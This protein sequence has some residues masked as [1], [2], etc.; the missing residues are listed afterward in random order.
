MQ[1][2]TEETTITVPVI[3]SVDPLKQWIDWTLSDLGMHYRQSPLSWLRVSDS[4]SSGDRL[5]DVSVIA[6]SHS[7]SLHHVLTYDKWTLIFNT[8]AIDQ[9]RF[10][11][12]YKIVSQYQ[13]SIDVQP[14]LP[15]NREAKRVL[16]HDRLLLIRP[17]GHIGLLTHSRDLQ[18][19]ADYLDTFLIRN[20]K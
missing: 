20:S 7:V 5:P 2:K 17:D 10:E 6:N 18:T 4:L 1:L 8:A 13:T 19:L 12:L 3:L 14:L 16:G 15:V 11:Q 9:E